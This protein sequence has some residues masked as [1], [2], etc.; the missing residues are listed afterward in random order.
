MD[1]PERFGPALGG[2][3]AVEGVVMGSCGFEHGEGADHVGVDEIGRA[4]DGAV[5]V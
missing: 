2:G 3:V 4:V 5:D 1:E